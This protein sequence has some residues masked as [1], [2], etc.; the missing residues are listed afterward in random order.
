MGAWNVRLWP[1]QTSQPL[2]L[3]NA[4]DHTA[5]AAE[6][7]RSRGSL[8]LDSPGKDDLAPTLGLVLQEGRGFRGRA[9]DWRDGK[10]AEPLGD[11]G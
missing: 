1:K 3:M 9:A 7:E 11:I 4:F 5:M 8:R 10:V 6:L 2:S